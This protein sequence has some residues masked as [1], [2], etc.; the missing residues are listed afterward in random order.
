M[1]Y[2]DTSALVP[3]FLEEPSSAAMRALFDENSQMITWCWTVPEA[4]S[5]LERRAREGS[6]DR[7]G[8]REALDRLMEMSDRWDEVTDV[9]A[10]RAKAITLLAR[11][12]IRAA[13]AAQLGAALL[14][15]DLGVPGVPFVTLDIR[16]ALAA[17]REGLRLLAA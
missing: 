6:L 13:D 9:N 10:V 5:A 2:W 12:E 14:L 8:R 16:L 11:H 17:E 1:R 15:E 4:V 7:V 3:I